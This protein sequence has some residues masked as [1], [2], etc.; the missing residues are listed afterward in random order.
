MK[1]RPE[2]SEER[3]LRRTQSKDICL[4]IALRLRYAPLS[5]EKR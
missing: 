3:R 2:R 4:S 5:E 1:F